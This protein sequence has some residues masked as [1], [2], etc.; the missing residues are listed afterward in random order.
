VPRFESLRD[1]LPSLYRPQ[2]DETVDP[3]LPLGR[4]DLAELTGA[5]GAIRFT[6]TQRDGSLVVACGKA[7]SVVLLRLAPG[8][9]PGSGYALE[10]R[11]L[12]RAGSLSTKPFAVLPVH[13]SVAAL[14]TT[15]LPS[16][17]AVQ[18]KQRSLLTL[19][20]LAVA[21][22]LERLNREAGEVMQSH[23]FAY[24]D[25]A[26]FSPFFLRSRALQGLGLPG[27]EDAPVRHFPY[28]D[29]LG[30]LAS[31]LSLP[32][33]Q[34]PVVQDGG[35][36]ASPETVE[37]YRQRI[38]RIV[39]LYTN[40]LGTIEALR[41]MTEAQLPVDIDAA[42]ERRDR[43]FDVEELAPLLTVKTAVSLAGQ[44]TDYVGP[45]MHWPLANDAVVPSPATAFVQ[46]PTEAELAETGPDG[47]HLFAPT[48]APVL[49]LY[50]GGP[51]RLGLAYRDTVPAG[52]TLRIR[53]SFASW[54]GLDGGVATAT[55]PPGADD[56]D[57]TA[58]GPWTADAGGPTT[59]VTSLLVSA[60]RALWAAAAGGELW[61]YDGAW[62][63]ALTGQPEIN[64]LAEDGLDLLLGTDGGLLRVARFPDGPFA[65]VA[66]PKPDGRVVHA[67]LRG[68][69]GTL[70]AGT[71]AG[72]GQYATGDKFKTTP[73]KL[74]VTSLATDS[75]GALYAGGAFGLVACRTAAKEWWWYS[76]ESA[77]DEDSEWV[78][79]DPSKKST[80]PDD[81]HVFV[82][83][84]TAIL[85]AS[86][87]ALWIGTEQGLARYVARGQ[88]GPVAFRTLLE[89]FP[90][91]CPGRVAALVADER[92][93]LW[94]CS[95]RG[96]LRYDGRDWSQFQAAGNGFVQ[97]GR[98][99]S[100]YP[101][102]AE[103]V[104]RGA[105]RFRRAGSAWERFDTTLASPA[106]V[107]F[108][109]DART[110]AEPPVHALAFTDGLAADIVDAWDPGDFSVSGSTP[111]D[112]TR[113]VLRVKVDGD[114][115]VVDGGIPALPRVPAG[116]S[117]WRYLSL[118]P[119]APTLPAGRPAWTI[120]GRLL[121][122]AEAAPDPEPGRYDQG[123]PEPLDEES[124]YDEAVFAFTPAAHVGLAW[125]PKRPLSVLVRLR[126]RGPSD[127]I[128]PAAL[129]RVFAGMQQ[130]RPAG[131]RAVLA[132]EEQRVRKE[133]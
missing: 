2:D 50:R 78:S 36:S 92:G 86:D 73:L 38:S 7:A 112:P 13:D 91:L 109:G 110:T 34:E 57:P 107:A 22:V 75:T 21:D 74:E 96:L 46:A 9:A 17:F 81:A 119:E 65:A 97:L 49:E 42:P 88:G 3:L 121:P 39:A 60:D 54:V 126:K 82:P 58:P 30:R 25:R 113:F 108:G 45:L 52:K 24:A 59:A 55:S 6:S 29:D 62:V 18:L 28:I 8:R 53:P 33:W 117:E 61:R 83:A 104:E 43:P 122:A 103:P 87:G 133:S 130:V 41:R 93:L 114:T 123:R 69:D 116:A 14:G 128:D 56:V 89:A 90:D 1:R 44:P 80:L 99:D 37:T 124:E 26:V 76:G 27:P 32:P 95:D 64:C 84:V 127:S 106:F 94:A 131:V 67:L 23:W 100:L 101:P 48:V 105:W 31:L 51:L 20:L 5:D 47:E 66:E 15:T 35:G 19:E 111:V 115:R 129:D 118:E 4:D 63:K 102:G 85:R 70:W 40:G 120:E 71:S 11:A 10:L 16:T 68:G 77:S 98:A 72:L 12:G 79:F 125:E 132:V